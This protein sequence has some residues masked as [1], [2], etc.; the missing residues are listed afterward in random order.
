MPQP[1]ARFS[2]IREMLRERLADQYDLG[3]RCLE[4]GLEQIPADVGQRL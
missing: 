2:S 1:I 4:I 3:R